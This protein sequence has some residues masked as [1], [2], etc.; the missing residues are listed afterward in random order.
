[1]GAKGPAEGKEK[2]QKKG[3]QKKRVLLDNTRFNANNADRGQCMG[4]HGCMLGYM[5]AML[6]QGKAGIAV[7]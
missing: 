4:V 1:M 5:H 3:S 6:R 7:E 2:K